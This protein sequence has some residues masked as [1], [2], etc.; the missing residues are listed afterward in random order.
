MNIQQLF[1]AL[2]ARPKVFA[3]VLAATVMTTLIVS[4]LLPKTY[5]GTVSLL[6][7]SKDEQSLSNINV[8]A[9][10][11]Q[12]QQQAAYMQ[13]QVDIIKS[14]KVVNKVVREL[15]LLDSPVAREEFEEATGG[16]GSFENWL[17]DGLLKWLSVETTQSSVVQIIYK[18]SDAA[19]A[20]RAANAFAKAYIDTML[21]LRVGPTQRTAEW[22]DEQLKGLRASL[23]DAQG[24]LT[25]YQRDKNIVQADERMDVE[26]AR[27]NELSTQMVLAQS[28]ASEAESRERLA[29]TIVSTSVDRLPEVLASPSIQRL[30]GELLVVE[31]RLQHLSSDLGSNHPQLQ[32]QRAEYN[33]LRAQLD[34]EMKRIVTG[35]ANAGQQAR[36][37]LAQLNSAVAEQRARVLR[38]KE[39]RN[40]I[41]VLSRDVET[42]QRAYDSAMQRFVVSK[43]ESGANR[44]NVSVLDSAIEPDKPA[45]PKIPLNIALSVVI[46]TM[47]GLC[48]VFFMEQFDRR[49]RSLD[50]LAHVEVPLLAQLNAWQPGQGLLGRPRDRDWALP[51]PG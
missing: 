5:V 48:V 19:F 22:F 4:L 11:L 24:K 47:L 6:L 3:L 45:R 12:A 39:F 23:E 1:A 44:T 18:S 26:N 50:D 17:A 8:L 14:H 13:T 21:E 36:Q 7:D 43:V 25:A 35:L 27:L 49:V 2:R 30:K 10:V 37:H 15:G 34:N 51:A 42:A 46:G 40:E 31:A 32:R 38:L 33:S 29:K 28:H 16:V 9:P 20:A 41:G